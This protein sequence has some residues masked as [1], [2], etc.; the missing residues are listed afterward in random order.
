MSGV[1]LEDKPVIEAAAQKQ[2]PEPEPEL[3]AED[4]FTEIVEHKI[5]TNE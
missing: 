4:F 5:A 3:S 2:L 1:S